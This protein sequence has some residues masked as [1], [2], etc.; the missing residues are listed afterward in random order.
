MGHGKREFVPTKIS[1]LTILL[2]SM[3]ILMG[4]A[5]VAPA[6]RPISEAFPDISVSVIPLVIA[7]PAVSVALTGF[8]VGYLADRFGKTKVFLSSIAIF[9]LAG[10]SG[11]FT[12]SF[13]IM[14]VGRFILGVGITGVSLTVTALI[15]EYW[16]GTDRMK[17]ISYQSAA[18]GIGALFFE[19]LGGSLADIGWHEPFLIYLI[20]IPIIILGSFSLREMKGPS[21]FPEVKITEFDATEKRRKILFCYVLVFIEMFLM[22]SLPASF[23][24]YVT[25]MGWNLTMCGLLLGTMGMSQA[26]FSLLYARSSNKF[27]EYNA[28]VVSFLL[29]GTGL[30]AL[31]I[32]S[33]A[34]AFAGMMLIGFSLGLLVPTVVGQLSLYS[35]KKTSGKIMGGYSVAFNMSTFISAIT[36]TP[37]GDAAGSYQ[38][39]FL[40]LGIFSFIVCG[41]FFA[42]E[43]TGRR[44]AAGKAEAGSLNIRAA[45]A[46]LGQMYERILVATDGS[47]YS[48]LASDRA[49]NIAKMNESNVTVLFVFDAERYSGLDGNIYSA[50]EIRHVGEEASK[51]VLE[52]AAE[53]GRERGIAVTT[54]MVF[55]HPAEAIVEES[56]CHDLVVCGSLGRTNISRVLIGSVAEKVAR[57]AYCPVLICRK[58]REE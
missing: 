35:T 37:M 54:K 27:R 53:A 29:M 34:A 16:S 33:M 2:S 39:M 45:D 49:M 56:K 50:D 55:G 24:Y 52:T 5:A 25:E 21:N 31:F 28:Y 36:I 10:V 43:F 40:I 3:V 9:T 48:R 13:W 46:D 57:M 38:S 58:H 4:A 26:G 22:F 23:S 12:D 8:G 32:L 44:A 51:K 19:T 42:A 17:A 11:Y 30:S 15:G 41:V 6:L 1:L 47:E 20:G 18:M 14:L 7:L